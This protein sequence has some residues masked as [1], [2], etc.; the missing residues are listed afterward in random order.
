MELDEKEIKQLIKFAKYLEV[1][2]INE[3]ELEYYFNDSEGIDFNSTNGWY[4]QDTVEFVD[5]Y[6]SINKTI[7]SILERIDIFQYTKSGIG[8]S[9]SCIFNVD[10]RT[11]SF[12]GVEDIISIDNHSREYN[13][14]ELEN[15]EMTEWFEE[16]KTNGIVSGEV[17]F[18]GGGDSGYVAGYIDTNDGGNLPLPT[19]VE[20]WIINDIDFN[21]YDNEGGQ[22]RYEF[23]FNDEYIEADLGQNMEDSDIFVIPQIFK[24]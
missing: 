21:W 24:F 14:A 17:T 15:N 16:M 19:F 18:E 3:V 6:D 23:Y 7:E 22:G 5:S 1:Y 8:G 2:G 12:K 20:T 4:S 11:L 9:I 13:L 10:T